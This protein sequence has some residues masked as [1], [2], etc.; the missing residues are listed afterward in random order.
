MSLFLPDLD[1]SSISPIPFSITPNYRSC[2][3]NTEL[4]I[5]LSSWIGKSP[6]LLFKSEFGVTSIFSLSLNLFE[7]YSSELRSDRC[8]SITRFPSEKLLSKF[9]SLWW[10]VLSFS[11][12]RP[13]QLRI[14]LISLK[15][16]IRYWLPVW[17]ELRSLVWSSFLQM[18]L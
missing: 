6:P 18:L 12:S 7:S 8:S 14:F 2:V 9:Y 13:R 10:L 11:K 5:V 3:F 17:S 4:L 15:N 16:C 1:S